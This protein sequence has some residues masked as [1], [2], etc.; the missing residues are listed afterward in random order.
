MI[1]LAILIFIVSISKSLAGDPK[2]PVTAIPEGLKKDV[3]AVI[4]EDQML[5][6]LMSRSKGKCYTYFV[7]TI[8]NPN[9]N[10]YAELTLDYSKLEKIADL[11]ASVY[12]AAGNLIK[13]MKKAD[14]YDQSAYDGYTLFSD[15]RFKSVDLGQATYPYT[16]EFEY[17]MEYDYIYGIDGSY[18]IPGEKVSVQH[19]S[20]QI[21]F[22]SELRPRFKTFN[23]STEPVKGKTK[24][25]LESLTWDFT[26][27]SP[28]K[29][30]PYAP[31]NSFLPVIK[32]APS[33]FEYSG[34]NGNMSSWESFGKWQLLLNK[35]KDILPEAAKSKVKSLTSTLSSTEEKV[36]VLYEYLQSKTRY[37]N[38]T[39]GVGG[40]QPF[41]ASVVDQVGYGDCKALSN[42]MIAL[43]KEA[44]IK[45]YYTKVY[46]GSYAPEWIADFPSH[47]TNHIIVAV[48]NQAD[49]IW[50]ECTSQTQ[51]FG[52]MGTFTG[53]RNALMVTESGGKVVRTPRYTADQN[54]QS[55]FATVRL[56]VAGDANAAVKMVFRGTQY[57]NNHLNESISNA[58]DQKKWLQNNIKIPAFNI[59]AFSV[60]E[61]RARI[62]SIE[63]DLSLALP[64]I[65]STSGKRIFLS[66]NLLNKSNYIPEKIE[67]R[68]SS[69]VLPFD[70]TD[71]DTI[72]YQV[73]E[74]IYPEFLPPTTKI[75]SRFGD[76]ESTYTMNQG[77]LVY[78]RRW[79]MRR[80]TFPPESYN[81]LVDFFKN[82]TRADNTKIVFLS[83]T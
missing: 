15:Y 65:A 29:I 61:K 25:G 63:I 13:K 41:E 9:G 47:Q 78:T 33:D 53:D 24:D 32:V 71:Y 45:G 72:E 14:I 70:F 28:I 49:T 73:P 44:G 80:G 66:P 68:K 22:P 1:R 42:Y 18:I 52:Y 26:N 27:L 16:V 82:V 30:E 58:E 55:T 36:K 46:A 76:Y 35:D 60:K 37:V 54:V 7:V 79:Q 17:T 59:L 48:P 81:E 6:T 57:E 62:P 3:H 5:Y 43:L 12:D 75:Q 83:K 34:Y 77:V 19:A 4:R 31:S 23:I 64:R 20:Y 69:V 21:N 2:F 74:N 8:L 50:L 51:P 67:S 38:I 10:D 39:L 40:L 56:D 11:Q